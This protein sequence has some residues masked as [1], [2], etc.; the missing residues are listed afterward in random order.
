MKFNETEYEQK[1]F[2]GYVSIKTA[3]LKSNSVAQE[4]EGSSPHS[5]QPATG[6]CPEL[7][8]SNPTPPSQSPQD[9]F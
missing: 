8:E 4:P 7:V 5:Q 9:P 3:K 2:N 6:T 1:A